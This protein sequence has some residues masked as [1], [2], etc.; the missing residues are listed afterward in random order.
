M[1]GFYTGSVGPDAG[2]Q[3]YLRH[4]EEAGVIRDERLRDEIDRK[5]AHQFRLL[6][7]SRILFHP[8]ALVRHRD[9]GLPGHLHSGLDH[10]FGL[11]DAVWDEK[12]PLVFPHPIHNAVD[13][14]R[15][16]GELQLGLT[17]L[18]GIE[19]I[20]THHEHRHKSVWTPPEPPRRALLELDGEECPAGAISET[21]KVND[22]EVVGAFENGEVAIAQRAC[23]RGT[24][25]YAAGSPAGT[26]LDRLLD[27]VLSLARIESLELPPGV[28]YI[29]CSPYHFYLNATGET[30]PAPSL[31]DGEMLAGQRDSLP[32]YGVVIIREKP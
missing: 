14:G 26:V 15:E 8:P 20:A 12:N 6:Q 21:I 27:R 10:G 29:D 16:R 18:F 11:F 1:E 4:L 9:A 24:A 25:L 31:P 17:E 3:E 7:D 13:L 32:P 2:S 22:A 30:L 19:V 28:E 23:G 5:R